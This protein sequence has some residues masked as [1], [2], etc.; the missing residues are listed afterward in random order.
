MKIIF[1]T[2]L[3]FRNIISLLEITVRKYIYIFYI[4][5][6]VGNGFDNRQH[7]QSANSLALCSIALSE[8]HRRKILKNWM[9]IVWNKLYLLMLVLFV[10]LSFEWDRSRAPPTRWRRYRSVLERMVDMSFFFTLL[11]LFGSWARFAMVSR[12]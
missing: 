9:T 2:V 4:V 8:C 1:L 12:S 6:M 7:H 11:T 3:T 5:C 10:Q